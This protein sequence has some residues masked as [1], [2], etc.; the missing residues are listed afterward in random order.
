[1]HGTFP[2][3]SECVRAACTEVSCR[4][5]FVYACAVCVSVKPGARRKPAVR[6][7]DQSE[8]IDPGRG[9]KGGTFQQQQKSQA[10]NDSSNFPAGSCIIVSI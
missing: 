8:A 1:M 3:L 7:I 5:Q 10:V 2:S 9:K 4:V 6:L